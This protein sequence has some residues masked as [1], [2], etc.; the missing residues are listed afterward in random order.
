[1]NSEEEQIKG[2]TLVFMLVV[3]GFYDL[4]Q[5]L[6]SFIPILGQVISM[7]ISVFAFLTF[8]LWFKTY[9]MNF[10]TPKRA[11][12]MGGGFLVELIPIL[13]MLP[14]WTA[15]VIILVGTTKV[16]ELAAKSAIG[17]VALTAVDKLA[18]T[19]KESLGTSKD[20][21]AQTPTR[22]RIPL[23]NTPQNDTIA[24][25]NYTVRQNRP[26]KAEPFTEILDNK[27]DKSRGLQTQAEFNSEVARSKERSADVNAQNLEA[28]RNKN[29][30]ININEHNLGVARSKERSAD[31]NAQ[32]LE[33]T[34]RKNRG[35][36][37]VQEE[38]S[39]NSN[40]TNLLNVLDNND[41]LI[42]TEPEKNNVGGL[43]E[44]LIINNTS[45]YSLREVEES[46]RN[47]KY[48]N[49]NNDWGDAL[50]ELNKKTDRTREENIKLTRAKEIMERNSIDN[51]DK[52]DPVLMAAFD[53]ASAGIRPY[54]RATPEQRKG[55][56]FSNVTYGG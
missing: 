27:S 37:D 40:D 16:K 42:Q 54:G 3:A 9:G 25:T 38:P 47:E 23:Q 18:S 41:K 30:V 11:L 45:S 44:P 56:K 36:Q 52:S 15:T 5:F 33:V 31:V 10:M 21:T 13:D 29:R 55:Y 28:A 39:K 22:T 24:P 49:E 7:L 50:D 53:K 1:M 43:K 35:E 17:G 34:R 32:N 20:S 26:Q 8:Y 48:G 2:M 12:T 14:A 51:N 6:I 46:M 19:R 4:I